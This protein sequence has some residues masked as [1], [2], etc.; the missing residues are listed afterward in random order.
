MKSIPV[1]ILLL[2]LA[3]C[4]TT[5]LYTPAASNENKR[6]TASLEELKQGYELFT[7]RCNKCHGLKSPD[8]RTPEQW[9]KTLEIMAPKTKHTVEQKD[10]VYEYLVNY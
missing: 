3:A 10:L 9:T 8:S 4:T 7:T 2:A 1:I 6:T 5:K